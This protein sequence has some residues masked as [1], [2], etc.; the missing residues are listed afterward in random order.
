MVVVIN[1]LLTNL[2]LTIG[3]EET[4]VITMIGMTKVLKKMLL[5]IIVLILTMMLI[6]KLNMVDIRKAVEV[7]RRKADPIWIMVLV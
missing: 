1:L 5:L 3:E 7:I 2:N 6:G 4:M